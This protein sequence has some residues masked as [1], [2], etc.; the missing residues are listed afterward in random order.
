MR[1]RI[2]VVAA[3][4]AFAVATSTLAG[5]T[6]QYVLTA[7]D[8]QTDWVVQGTGAAATWATTTVEYPVA[9]LSTIR[10]TGPSPGSVGGEYSL[11]GVPTGTTF[12][13]GL[14]SGDI[15]DGT[16]DGT[17][18][19]AVNYGDGNVMRFDLTWSNPQVLFSAGGGTDVLGITYDPTNNSLWVSGWNTGTITD[20]SLTGTVLS[21]FTVP[22][23]EISCLAFDYSDDTLWFGSQNTQGTFYQYSRTGTSLGSQSYASL[24]TQ[25]TLG[26]EFP[27]SAARGPGIPLLGVLGL[28]A[29]I[30]M[31]AGIGYTILRRG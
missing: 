14:T 30:V 22:Y 15:Y 18:L 12:T 10:T 9:V 23:T 21:S 26:G 7:G 19:Y 5:P 27:L 29:L 31:L 17:Y 1:R 16:T 24:T 13:N 11:V 20:Y 28:A 8:Q 6:G 2:L 25:N 3:V 4:L